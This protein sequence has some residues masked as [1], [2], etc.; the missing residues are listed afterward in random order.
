M[1]TVELACDVTIDM[2]VLAFYTPIGVK[3]VEGDWWWLTGVNADGSLHL[4]AV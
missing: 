4:T 1:R 2:I 3:D